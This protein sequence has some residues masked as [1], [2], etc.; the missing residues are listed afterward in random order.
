MIAIR[1]RARNRR[2]FMIILTK[3][4]KKKEEKFYLNSD[5]IET[6]EE[7]PDTTLKLINGKTYVVAEDSGEVFQKILAYKRSIYGR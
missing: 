7:K 5:L 6:I 1:R 2:N 3:L 4:N